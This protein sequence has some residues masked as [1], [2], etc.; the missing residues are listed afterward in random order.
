MGPVLHSFSDVFRA[1]ESKNVHFWGLTKHHGVD[2][3]PWNT[4]KYGYIPDHIQSSF[5]VFRSNFIKAKAFQHYWEKLPM[6]NRYEEAIGWH[7]AIFTED[8]TRMGFKSDVYVNTEDIKDYSDYPLMLFPR[9]LVQ[10]RGCPVFKR[11]LFY[12]IYTEFLAVSY[13]QSAVDFYEYIKVNNLYDVDL[14]WETLL[15]TANMADIKDRMQLNYILP[16]DCRLSTNESKAKVALFIHMYYVDDLDDY[17]IYFSN[18]PKSADIY[19]TT[20]TQSKIDVLRTA[21]KNLGE[22]RIKIRKIQNQGRDVSALLIGLKDVVNDYDLICFMHDKKT[23]YFKPY[24]IGESFKFHLLENILGSTIYVENIIKTFEDNPRLGLLMPPPPIHSTFSTLP[25]TEWQ[26]N[27]AETLK[28]A[29]KLGIGVP[30]TEARPPIAP[31]G[32]MFWFRPQSLRIL[33]E[34]DF[35]YDDFPV[36]PNHPTDGTLMHQ[37]ERIYPFAAQQSGYYSAWAMSDYFSKFLITNYN[38]IASDY[39]RAIYNKIGLGTRDYYVWLLEN[40]SLG[41][42]N[43]FTKAGIK[44]TT[45]RTVKEV[46]GQTGLNKLSQFYRKIKK[47]K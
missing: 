32:T 27:Y 5:M 24:L 39:N 8:F 33:F 37:I 47:D 23:Q 15:R 11:K 21:T 6:V 40:S 7:E 17:L 36:E 26:V 38:R 16:R 14:I 44:T 46:F 10:N 29:R 18:F 1:M 3:D 12:N 41:S 45:K 35:S 30:I 31:L 20:D 13:G 43:V 34:H 28:L 9:E 19:I 2:H 4:C 22:D 42:S 25:G